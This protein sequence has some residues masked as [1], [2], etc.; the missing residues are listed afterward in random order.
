MERFWT[1][2]VVL[3]G[4]AIVVM[5]VALHYD[6]ARGRF[7]PIPDRVYA[8]DTITGQYCNPWPE[9]KG[10]TEWNYLPRCADLAKG[11]R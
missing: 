6:H 11:W 5:A 1:K 9:G 7:V 8:L 10:V 4:F 2:T 3:F